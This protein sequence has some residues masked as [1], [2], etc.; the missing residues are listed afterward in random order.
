MNDVITISTDKPADIAFDY[1]ALRQQGIRHIER[2]ASRVWTDY[3]VHDPGITSLEILCYAITDLSYRSRYAIPDLLMSSKEGAAS[4]I[5]HFQTA[6]NIFP[7]KPLTINDYR[8][9]LINVVGIKNA[10]LKKKTKAILADLTQKT[11][12]Q[13]APATSR[14]KKVEV[15][16]Y[17]DVLLEFDTTIKEEDAKSSKVA[18]IKELL[19]ANRNLDEDFL[20]IG[21]V[22]QQSFRLCSEIEIDPAADAVRLLAEIFFNIQ[23]HLSPIVSFYSLEQMLNDGYT[24]DKIYEGPFTSHGFIKDGE[25]IASE[26]KQ[27]VRLS[28]I[29]SI[30]L[31][32]KGVSSVPD[33]LFNDIQQLKELDDKWSIDV[34]P[35]MQAVVDILQ[36]N[37]VIYKNE[38]PV[39]VK[40]DKVKGVADEMMTAHLLK[41]ENITA[42]DIRFDTGEFRNI[43]SYQSVQ[44]HFPRTYGI[45]EWGLPED[46]S[47]ERKK[48]AKQLQAYLWLF[49]QTLANYLAQLSSV[50]ALFSL[51][52]QKQTYFT[53]VVNDFNNVESLFTT[54][55]EI[56]KNIQQPVESPEIFE[57]RRNVFL[58]HLLSRFAE[59][60]YD[61]TGVLHSL[62]P[63]TITEGVVIKT[64][65]DFLKQYPE[66]SASRSLGYNYGLS[67]QLWDTP[68]ISG[69]EKRVQ[70][71]LGIENV[72]RRSLVNFF[73]TIKAEDDGSG[74]KFWFEFIDSRNNTVLLRSGEKFITAQQAIN[75][76]EV[77]W[78]LAAK[79][80]NFKIVKDS[81]DNKFAYELRDKLNK[82][83]AIGRKGTKKSAEAELEQLFLLFDKMSE[84]GM[85]LIEHLLLFNEANKYHLP[86]CIDDNCDECS[87]TDPYSFKVSIILPAYAGRFT[88]MDFRRYVE[89]VVR[90][91]M[92]SHLMPKVCWIS[93]EQL[94]EFEDAYREWL[95][96]KAGMALD[97]D[98]AVLKRF[99][100][101]LTG[102]KSIY[103]EGHLMNCGSKNDEQLF[104]LNKN[105]LGT[106]KTS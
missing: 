60:F 11:L 52:N 25:L 61:Y 65:Q 64:K 43:A 45:S 93:N 42:E 82:L 76:L 14:T 12:V 59:S 72:S 28:D 49:D 6:K 34:K 20:F 102:L 40:M 2:L 22:E 79:R 74:K 89:K 53:Q 41:N 3:N 58:D 77:T 56:Q 44:H 30:I 83:I 85:F 87:D 63:S 10:W 15:K 62:F 46:A 13:E 98:G 21:T 70:K 66:Y 99:I 80:E 71:L 36:S 106:L 1:P 5:E 7:N 9:L 78:V 23:L 97:T 29:M 94:K 101:I 69:L 55:V 47:P 51:D 4:V 16:G 91:E 38:T 35:G 86:V 73:T 104:L 92:P 90:E 18:E 105:S 31:N 96:V 88:N 68:N 8:K 81:T 26:L 19:L 33:I 75:E 84:E 48:Q 103:P 27:K 39:R 100:S 37:V 50:K 67:N 32:T 17:Y 54:P 57:Q 95:A 24:T